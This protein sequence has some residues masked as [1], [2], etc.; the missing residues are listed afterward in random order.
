VEIMIGEWATDTQEGTSIFIENFKDRGFG[1]T[2]Y[3][4]RPTTGRGSG[5]M[6]YES[7]SSSPTIYLEY[8]V[9][10]LQNFY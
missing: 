10:A 2:Y 5:N 6:L 3:A 9:N 8:V 4:W 7:D 1:W